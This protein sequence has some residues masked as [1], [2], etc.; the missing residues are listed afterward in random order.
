[1]GVPRSTA[2]S[3]D[4]A[5][6]TLIEVMVASFVLLVGVLAVVGLLNAANGATNRTRA[7]DTATNLARELIEG[8]RSIPYE[9]VSS[10]GVIAELQRLPGLNDTDA[11]PYTLRCGTVTYSVGINVCVMDDPKD[12]GGPRP[13]GASATFCANSVAPGT[14]DKNPE[15][16]KRVTVTAEW[17][18]QTRTRRV[19][20]TG[21]INNP[22]S[23]SGPAVRFLAPRG[24]SSP[25]TV[26][27]DVDTNTFDLTTSSKPATLAWM[28]DGSRQSAPITATGATGLAWQFDWS[29]KTLDD[30]AYVIGAEA[31]D[32]YGVSGPGRQETVVLNRH[33]ARRPQQVTGGRTAFGTVEI[34]WT[35]NSERDIAGY[36][37]IREG[38][39][40]PVCPITEQQLKTF[41]TDMSPPA[42]GPL[43]YYVR[44][45]DRDA[46]G[47]LR[48]SENSLPLIVVDTNAAPYGVANLT[49]TKL[50]NGDTKL[51]WTRPSP[52][53]PDAGDSISFF[54]IYRDGVSLANRYDR[55]FDF[56][57]SASVT[58]TD[59][60]TEGV[61]HSYS[62]TAVDQQYAES[63][64]GTA[65][66]G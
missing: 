37:V 66:I 34:E 55:Y 10:P 51:T 20:Q 1:M 31:Y 27:A 15:D 29:I 50:S 8:S 64:F 61:Q 40:A 54:R 46:A 22:G 60:D 44:A 28:L 47:N 63:P 21:I 49:L 19:S 35:A 56:T 3:R 36:D 4:Q 30:G 14:A 32:V 2:S 65:V 58:W 24:Y 7:H 9:R 25:F 17:T 42:N 23:A 57:G 11:G 53:D 12:G 43:R 52:E 6:F 5:G 41:C 48:V 13:A 62:V 18:E 39:V 59:T 26:L 38:A 33:L 45:Y 16:Y